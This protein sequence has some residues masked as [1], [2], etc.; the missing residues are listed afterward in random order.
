LF[1]KINSKCIEDLNVISKTMKVLE[2]KIDNI[3]LGI[4]FFLDMTPVVQATKVKIDQWNYNK[5]KGF[6]TAKETINSM[7]WT[8]TELEKIFAHYSS[9]NNLISRIH[10]ELNTKNQII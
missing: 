1:T 3:G 4:D 9:K 7:K 6:C 8:P 2:E 10:K 5:L